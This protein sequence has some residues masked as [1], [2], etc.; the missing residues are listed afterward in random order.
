[1]FTNIK[2]AIFDLDGTLVDSMWVWE[3]IDLDYLKEIGVEETINLKDLKNDINH[4]SF[5]ETGE[6]FK[7]RFNIQE[8]VDFICNRWH[9]MAFNHYKTN[10]KLK[11]FA[12]E[13]L[14]KLKEKGIKIALA[15]SNSKELLETCLISN[16]IIDFFDSITTTNE[17]PF[18]KDHPDVYLLAAKRLNVA[19]ENC[20][21]FEDIL[22]AVE[23]ALKANM[24][25][26]SVHD[27]A[28]EFQREAL[29][30]KSHRH[31]DSFEELILEISNSLESL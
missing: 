11:A 6:Y 5:N 31:I 27:A 3:Q 18:G 28:A 20:I 13:F 24:T 15:T 30:A 8:S 19:P 2:A 22:P 14:T 29:M 21:V 9:E 4:L 1:M 16:G 26:V 12:K 7:K 17:V 10:V 23:G 25:V